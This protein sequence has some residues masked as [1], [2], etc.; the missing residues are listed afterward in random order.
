M[1]AKTTKA[2]TS[3]T[4]T[5]DTWPPIASLPV[6]RCVVRATPSLA[7]PNATDTR[8][9][10]VPCS[11]SSSR[12][13]VTFVLSCV[14]SFKSSARI[15]SV[16]GAVSA[17]RLLRIASVAEHN[18]PRT[19][20]PGT[21]SQAKHVSGLPLAWKDQPGT[22]CSTLQARLFVCMCPPGYDRARRRCCCTDAADADT[23]LRLGYS[24]RCASSGAP[25]RPRPGKSGQG[26][27]GR[28]CMQAS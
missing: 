27:R 16:G 14:T 13:T 25:F 9:K 7:R 23:T 1:K 20:S 4:Q 17:A 18:D 26:S 19:C 15:A 10:S 2:N 11:F 21:Y 3:S 24:R 6:N 8:S 28:P 5:W 22:R 12:M